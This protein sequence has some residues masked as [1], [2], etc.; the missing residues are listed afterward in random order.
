VLFE[1]PDQTRSPATKL[2]DVVLGFL[3]ILVFAA[4][5][6]LILSR[7]PHNVIGWLCWA[8]GFTWSLAAFGGDPAARRIGADSV[9]ILTA[10]ALQ[11][12]QVAFLLSLLGLLPL[13]VL[14]FP[15][16]RL[17]S[18]R[19]R[20]IV[21]IFAA[22]LLLYAASRVLQPGQLHDEL[23]ATNPLGL[24]SAED[25]LQLIGA[26]LFWLFAL[27]VVLVLGSLVLRFRRSR[28]E[29]RQ[30]L[31][32]LTY[33]AA[34]LAVLLPTVGGMVER[35]GPPFLGEVFFALALSMVPAAIGVAVLRY[36]L[37]DIDRI[38]NR[39]LVYGLLTACSLASTPSL[40]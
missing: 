37:Y 19:W 9:P 2:S 18:H 6:A 34:L 10:L 3:P 33:A 17:P 29:E 7:R 40:S 21:W 16:G 25:V 27:L 31:K 15:T 30:Q 23:P 12:G 11:L 24:E 14:L 5:G 39:T 26:A 35:I 32:W 1:L 36:R 22:G 28:G 4:V 38:I 8:I 13:L 20:P